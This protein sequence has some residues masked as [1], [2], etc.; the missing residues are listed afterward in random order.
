MA[1]ILQRPPESGRE[2]AAGLIVGDDEGVVAYPERSPE[3]GECVRPDDRGEP[4]A[5]RNRL[6]G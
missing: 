3:V 5:L 1:I 4:S 2:Q 6:P